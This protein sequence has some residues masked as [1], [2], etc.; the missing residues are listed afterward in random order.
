[1]SSG[2]EGCLSSVEVFVDGLGESV[3][4]FGGQEG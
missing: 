1:M 3:D 4:V 2:E